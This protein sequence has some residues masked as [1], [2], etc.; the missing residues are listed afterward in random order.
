MLKVRASF[1]SLGNQDVENYLYVERL[2]FLPI[3]PYDHGRRIAKLCTDGRVHKSGNY[4]GKGKDFQHRIDVGFLKNRLNVSFDYFIRNTLDMLGPA[5]SYPVVLGTEV[6]KSNNANLRT[7]GFEVVMEWRDRIQDFSYSAKFLLAD[8][9][10][11]L[12]VTTIHRNYLAALSMKEPN[13]ER[14]GDIQPWVCL[15]LMNRPRIRHTINPICHLK[16]GGR[17]MYIMRISIKMVKST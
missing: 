5:E 14:S 8:A 17:V 13:W 12:P 11:P 2:P 7:T 16:S 1:G 9:T 15:N 6:P 3:L 10:Q 4:L